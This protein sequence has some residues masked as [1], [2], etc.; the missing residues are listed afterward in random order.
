M[1]SSGLCVSAKCEFLQ[2]IHQPSDD[3]R[4]ALY[5]KAADLSFLTTTTY[6]TAGEVQAKGYVP[7]GKSLEGY[8]CKSED[9]KALLGWERD[10]VWKNASIRADGA[11]IYNASRDNRALVVVA[12]DTEIIST[13]G[14]F[15]VSM[16][17]VDSTTAP[18]RLG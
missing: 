5:T 9:F 7:G 2:G 12:F 4:I 8:I 10:P 1:I 3:Y 16:P 18:I 15:R 11:M 13:N 6:V 14:N 17:S